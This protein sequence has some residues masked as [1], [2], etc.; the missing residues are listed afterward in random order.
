M[1][2][3]LGK[4][5]GRSENAKSDYRRYCAGCHGD[6][7]DGNGENAMWLEPQ[8]RDLTIA[9][10]K[11]R[12]TPTGTLPTDEDLYDT[13]GRGLTN[14]NMPIWNTFSNQQKA[15]LVAYIH[16]FSPAS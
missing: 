14:S 15:D 12:S 3:R 13:I 8:P 10:F 4:L 2:S 6:L 5:T 7:G 16:T 11:C 1:Q 9:T